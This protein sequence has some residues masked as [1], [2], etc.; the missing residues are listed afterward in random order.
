VNL[1][2]NNID[3]IENNSETLIGAIKDVGVEIYAEKTKCK[4]LSHHQ[5]AG[6]N[7]DIEIA[8]RSFE[9]VSQ[10]RLF[11]DDSNKSKLD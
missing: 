7:W 6:Q 9:N 2:V 4:L 5:N 3:T 11:G 8:N 10:F 1:L